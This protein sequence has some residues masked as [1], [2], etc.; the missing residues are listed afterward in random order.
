MSFFAVTLGFLDKLL[1]QHMY[2]KRLGLLLLKQ[3]AKGLLRLSLGFKYSEH[4]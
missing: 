4:R 3:P 2:Q 1:I